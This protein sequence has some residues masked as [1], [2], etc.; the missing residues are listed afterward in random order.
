MLSNT[1]KAVL[2]TLTY[3]D[4]FDYPLKIRQIHAFLIGRKISIGQLSK[5]LQ[6]MI[7]R[8]DISR[9]NNYYFLNGKSRSLVLRKRREQESKKKI[10]SARI[11]AG[12][13]GRIPTVR[14]IGVSGSLSMLNA[15][16]RDDIDLFIITSKNTLWF[17]RFIVN[18]V[19]MVLG[20]KRSKDDSF[21][22]DRIC[23]NMF[24]SADSSLFLKNRNQFTAHEIAQLKILVNKNQTYQKFITANKWVFKYLPNF[25]PNFEFLRE[26]KIDNLSDRVLRFSDL[27]F[28]KLQ[29]FYMKSRV[30]SERISLGQAWFHPKDKTTLVLSLFRSR[31]TS[32]IK[33]LYRAEFEAK[34]LLQDIDI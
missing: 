32:Y 21:G 7:M 17:T 22:M 19:L 16:K 8:G 25:L 5:V 34:S 15:D 20:N 33:S 13:L 28:F 1:E 14:L 6:T 23:P 31:R 4:I 26:N 3:S 27:V 9:R 29:F 12:I 18:I 24:I 30:T 2:A 11:V 10:K